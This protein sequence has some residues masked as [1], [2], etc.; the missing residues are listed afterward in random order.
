[1]RSVVKESMSSATMS[2]SKPIRRGLMVSVLLVSAMLTACGGR[3]PVTHPTVQASTSRSRTYLD[4][5]YAERLAAAS[6]IK[7]GDFQIQSL[8]EGFADR[9]DLL[10]AVTA[11]AASPWILSLQINGLDEAIALYVTFPEDRELA[12]LRL[13]P[14]SDSDTD[15][16]LTLALPGKLHGV[17]PMALAPMA[18]GMIPPL[19][20]ELTFSSLEAGGFKQNPLVFHCFKQEESPK[21]VSKP[22]TGSGNRV[23]DLDAAADGVTVNFAWTE[24]NTGDYSNDGVVVINDL[25]P[26]AAHFNETVTTP[27]QQLIDGNG[28]TVINIADMTPLAANFG[29]SIAGYDLFVLPIPSLST[30]V[31]EE[32]FVSVNPVPNPL[33]PGNPH[34]TVPR[35]LFY[36]GDPPKAPKQHIRYSFRSDFA[37]GVYAFAVRAYSL[38]DDDYSEVCFSNI[39]KVAVAP[40]TN[41]PPAWVST[42]GIQNAKPLNRTVEVTFG[43]ASDPDGDSVHFVVYYDEGS[44]VDPETAMQLGPVEPEG[45]PPF[46]ETVSGLTNG[47][48]YA[49][50]VRVYD[51][52]G[53]EEFPPNT[54]VLTARPTNTAPNPLPW[55]YLRKDEARTGYLPDSH[56]QEPLAKLW[57]RSYIAAPGGGN[58]SCPVLDEQNVYIGS[59]DGCVYAFDQLTGEP[60]PAYGE[61]G[62]S[63]GSTISTCTAALY[64]DSLVIGV[65]PGSY[66]ILRR[67]DAVEQGHFD[68]DNTNAVRSSP[69]VLGGIVYAGSEEGTVYAFSVGDG[70]AVWDPPA[71]VSSSP[72]SSSPATDGEYIYVASEDGYVHKLTLDS[73]WEVATSPHLGSIAYSSP[74]LYP[75]D[76]PQYV[77]IGADGQLGGENYFYALSAANLQIEHSYPIERG[78]NGSPLVIQREG[79]AV[80]VVGE[81]SRTVPADPSGKLYAFDLETGEELWRTDDIGRIFSSPAASASR[82]FVGSQNGL[83]YVFDYNG[84]QCGPPIDLEAP[85]YTSPAVIDDRLYVANSN[86]V[87]FCFQMEP[88]TIPPRWLDTVG[89]ANAE[90]DFGEVTVHWG[91]AEDDF[92]TRV[93]YQLFYADNPN[94]NCTSPDGTLQGTILVKDLTE[95][96]HTVQGLTDGIRYYFVVRASDRPWS[97]SPNVDDN[98]EVIGATP[99]WNVLRAFQLGDGMLP[100]GPPLDYLEASWTDSEVRIAYSDEGGENP[101][102]IRYFTWDGVGVPTAPEEVYPNPPDGFGLALGLELSRNFAAQAL[103][104]FPGFD[105]YYY[106]ERTSPGSWTLY[107]DPLFSIPVHPAISVSHASETRLMAVLHQESFPSQNVTVMVRRGDASDWFEE[108]LLTTDLVYPM[109]IRAFVAPFASIGETPL[110]LFQDC[111]H[112]VPGSFIPDRGKLYVGKYDGEWSI[113]LLDD[114]GHGD[115]ADTGKNITICWDDSEQ[116]LL[117]AYYDFWMSDGTP[118]GR[119]RLAS[120]SLSEEAP[121]EVAAV[122]VPEDDCK[123]AH[124]Y[125]DLGLAVVDGKP[126]IASFSRTEHPGFENPLSVNKLY[127]LTQGSPGAWRSELVTEDVDEYLYYNAPLRLLPDGPQGYP[128]LIYIT[129]EEAADT[130][131]IWQ[132]GPLAG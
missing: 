128:L 40:S 132:R 36:V 94:V 120:I 28:D 65:A 27:E 117:A 75:Q 91:L 76:E 56:L 103:L 63:V 52:W 29:S 17:L 67:S 8:G 16:F 21:L 69:V 18:G 113:Q 123:E 13:L 43:E 101:G 19:R 25:T 14:L 105:H 116:R 97:D 37:S 110:V 122:N 10:Q 79:R 77:L 44:T 41:H 4:D 61:D 50:M 24:N 107:A 90:T 15:D 34:P 121:E 57:S 108:E 6:S 119:I 42:A 2:C 58:E 125:H 45:T 89:A 82:I 7:A 60:V 104:A 59:T 109:Y 100:D 26:L 99:P 74:V 130:I 83:L 95:L 98:Y 85:V 11:Q 23:I 53:A 106:A 68:L 84:V 124:Y 20:I 96:S 81:M 78:V 93:Y 51:Q 129:G 32:D 71:H 73:G 48:L 62:V 38:I 131:V 126:A 118:Q 92:Y 54:E 114:G 5:F 88:D 112:V 39:E 80:I 64:D 31:T 49:F 12:S 102:H 87:L 9:P 111:T 115:N 55:P 3:G 1:M 30:P 66:R 22:F 70:T 35:T 46:T 47:T 72:I 33:D 127:Y 86:S